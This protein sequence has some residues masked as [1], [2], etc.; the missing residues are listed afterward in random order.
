MGAEMERISFCKKC[1]KDFAWRLKYCPHCGQHED[2]P[3]QPDPVPCEHCGGPPVSAP[4]FCQRCGLRAGQPIR[5]LHTK[6]VGVTFRNRDR[7]SRQAVLRNLAGIHGSDPCFLQ[8]QL[9]HET[10][11]PKDPNAVALLL[12]SGEGIGYLSAD[13]A[14]EVVRHGQAG[15]NF[16]CYLLEVTGGVPEAPTCGANL[17]LLHYGPKVK[18][19]AAEAYVR[20]N[21]LD[22]R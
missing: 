10:D 4:A 19:L 21:R 16:G 7:T 17:L 22:E 20:A 12:P 5:H 18:A 9:D 8:L 13:L 3:L 1:G 11:N 2:R 15:C 14:P 6:A